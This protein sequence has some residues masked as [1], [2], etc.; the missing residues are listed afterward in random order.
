MATNVIFDD[1]VLRTRTAILLGDNSLQEVIDRWESVDPLLVALDNVELFKGRSQWSKLDPHHW[2]LL[3]TNT[4]NKRDTVLKPEDRYNDEKPIVASLLFL[5]MGLVH[6]IQLRSTGA[7]DTL[8]IVRISEIDI[9]LE[10]TVLM[11]S[12]PKKKLPPTGGLQVVVDNT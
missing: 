11:M 7:V 2:R 1:Y 8:R 12:Q 5:V 3:I 6:C 9:T 4:L 10:F